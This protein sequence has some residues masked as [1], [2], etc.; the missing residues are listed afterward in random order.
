[1]APLPRWRC[2]APNRIERG[3]PAAEVVGHLLEETGE[4]QGPE[5]QVSPCLCGVVSGSAVLCCASDLQVRPLE[6]VPPPGQRQL[7]VGMGLRPGWTVHLGCVADVPAVLLA[8]V[9]TAGSAALQA[10]RGARA[11]AG[12]EASVCVCVCL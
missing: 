1:M 6:L 2:G 9:R 7:A 11:A 3:H 4:L 12:G 8:L 10:T 5:R